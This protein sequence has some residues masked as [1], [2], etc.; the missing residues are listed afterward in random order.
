MIKVVA[1]NAFLF[2]K[3]IYFYIIAGLINFIIKR[4]FRLYRNQIT[5]FFIFFCISIII[6]AGQHFL[7]PKSVNLGIVTD[8]KL[9][10]AEK[11]IIGRYSSSGDINWVNFVKFFLFVTL[12]ILAY[13]KLRRVLQKNTDILF[14]TYFGFF[15]QILIILDL[16]PFIRS[17]FNLH[18][19][20]MFVDEFGPR[21]SLGFFEPSLG[22]IILAPLLGITWVR[23]KLLSLF[24]FVIFMIFLR[25][26]SLFVLYIIII[27]TQVWILDR[28]TLFFLGM[29]L[30]VQEF[31]VW[32]LSAFNLP[33]I[34]DSAY[35]RLKQFGYQADLTG[36]LFGI[37]FGQFTSF[38]PIVGV[39]SQIG[40]VGLLAFV[41]MV[42]FNSFIIINSALIAAVSPRLWNIETILAITLVIMLAHVKDSY[43]GSY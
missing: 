25:S 10:I 14:L 43:N 31:V 19:N 28:V 16:A 35:V 24:L 38:F 15:I 2:G 20:F 11:S 23:S 33:S 26:G 17:Y 6:I 39:V 30:I 1:I 8:E 32:N 9:R 21:N 36:I 37:D 18:N 12:M 5:I 41:T 22:A 3:G 40:V 27:L 13:P 7:I 42:K 34:F 29:F 4:R